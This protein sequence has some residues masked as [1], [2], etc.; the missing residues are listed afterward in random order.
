MEEE[1]LE[2][3]AKN[4]LCPFQLNRNPGLDRHCKGK[5]CMAWE[6]WTETLYDDEKL[7]HKRTGH[8]PK[9]PPQGHCGMLPP[10]LNCGYGG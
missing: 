3:E 10:E 5:L 6:E 4:K 2:S 7:P 1:M 9:D 8:K